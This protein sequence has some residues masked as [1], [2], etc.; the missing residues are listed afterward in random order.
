MIFR[1]I[2]L[3]VLNQ[4]P[5]FILKNIYPYLQLLRGCQAPL[6]F[7]MGLPDHQISR[8]DHQ[9]KHTANS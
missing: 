2:P 1:D 9:S 3:S 4:S 6:T 8:D 7:Q 5:S